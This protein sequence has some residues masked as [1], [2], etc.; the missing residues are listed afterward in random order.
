[1]MGQVEKAQRR[2]EEMSEAF[3]SGSTMQEIADHYGISRQRVQVLLAREGVGRESGGQFLGLYQQYGFSSA[4][5]FSA[6]KRLYPGCLLR[7]R[8]QKRNAES[9]R[10]IE[11]R[12]TLKQWLDE[13]GVKWSAR[14]R[15]DGLVMCRFNDVGPYEPGNVYIATAAQNA[16][17]YQQRKWHGV[18]VDKHASRIAS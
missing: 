6:A 9:V 2:R 17:D 8:T 13:W 7:F 12:F 11:F 5:E 10:G 14:G 16:S 4:A 18:M 3:V 15:G 1:M